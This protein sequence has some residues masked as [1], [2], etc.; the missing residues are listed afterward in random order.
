[1]LYFGEDTYASTML[2]EINDESNASSP[3]SVG[4]TD[5]GQRSNSAL[6]YV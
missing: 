1:M 4:L 2:A 6:T 5:A 3:V